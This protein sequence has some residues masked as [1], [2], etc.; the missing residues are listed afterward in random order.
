M[1][2]DLLNSPHQLRESAERCFRLARNLTDQRGQDT[3]MDY[4]RELL[5][6]AERMESALSRAAS[7]F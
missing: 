2:D 3:L 5:D 7:G 1:D 6:R 4:G